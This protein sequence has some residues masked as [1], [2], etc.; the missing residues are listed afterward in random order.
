M[1][2][3]WLHIGTFH[4][5]LLNLE[6]I[7]KSNNVVAESSETTLDV[8]C[9]SENV[10]PATV[11]F[12]YHSDSNAYDKSSE[13]VYLCAVVVL[14]EYENKSVNTFAFLDQGSTRSLCDKSFID[15]LRASVSTEQTTLETI[16]GA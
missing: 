7:G 1:F 16:T 14:V 11:T 4:H 9:V 6:R 3:D 8:T 2:C 10:N 12:C 5:T 15:L 13:D